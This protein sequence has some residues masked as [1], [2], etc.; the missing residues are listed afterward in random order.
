MSVS[1]RLAALA[2]LKCMRT[3]GQPDFPD[4]SFTPPVGATRVLVLRG[5]VFAF[6]SGI[7]PKAPAFRRS[8]A[9]CGVGRP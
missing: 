9:A 5:M 4:P 8:A 3:R 2:F 1:Q 7:D 6:G